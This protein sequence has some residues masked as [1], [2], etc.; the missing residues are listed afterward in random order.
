MERWSLLYFCLNDTGDESSVVKRGG[1]VLEAKHE[2]LS[3][4]VIVPGLFSVKFWNVCPI[5]LYLKYGFSFFV[6]EN[7]KEIRHKGLFRRNILTR[8]HYFIVI[9]IKDRIGPSP[10]LLVIRIIAIGNNGQGL[11]RYVHTDPKFLDSPQHL[12]LDI[13]TTQLMDILMSRLME[14]NS[15]YIHRLVSLST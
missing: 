2:V 6:A 9:R 3:A 13:M 1:F 7:L 12:I 11:K 8:V 14:C 5:L 15:H 10:I 4:I